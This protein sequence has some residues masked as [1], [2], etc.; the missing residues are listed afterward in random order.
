MT[1]GA[2][3]KAHLARVMLSLLLA[4]AMAPF[5]ILVGVILSLSTGS[6]EGSLTFWAILA[7]LGGFMLGMRTPRGNKTKGPD[8]SPR[9]KS[10]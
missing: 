4:A 6:S 1:P 5:G 8:I 7:A 3:D 2:I 10:D 9:E